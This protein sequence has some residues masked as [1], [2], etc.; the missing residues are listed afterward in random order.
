MSSCFNDDFYDV[1]AEIRLNDDGCL[2]DSVRINCHTRTDNDSLL[3]K[4]RSFSC[5]EKTGD[6]QV[7]SSSRDNLR[8]I[9]GETK[10][11]RPFDLA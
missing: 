10:K 1:I 2:S 4:R 7:T 5:S 9:S 11:V 3:V 8:D 6:V